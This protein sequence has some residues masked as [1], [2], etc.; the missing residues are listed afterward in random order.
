LRLKRPWDL[1][2]SP[3]IASNAATLKC[4]FASETIAVGYRAPA[5]HL[6]A[7]RSNPA[8]PEGAKKTLK[9]PQLPS[10]LVGALRAQLDCFASLA[11]TIH[12]KFRIS[13]ENVGYA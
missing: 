7:K 12:T 1:F 10:F 8:A 3:T 9:L 4:P 6:R 13:D 2:G 11:M 5:R